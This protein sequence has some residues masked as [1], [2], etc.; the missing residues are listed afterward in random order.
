MLTASDPPACYHAPYQRDAYA[1]AMREAELLRRRDIAQLDLVRRLSQLPDEMRF[2][3][4]GRGG[5]WRVWGGKSER[6]AG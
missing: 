1:W 4:S 5:A 3:E 2:D 6:W